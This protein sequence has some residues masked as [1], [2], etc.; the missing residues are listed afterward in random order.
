MLLSRATRTHGKEGLVARER[1][2]RFTTWTRREF[3]RVTTAFGLSVPAVSR[4]RHVNADALG[5]QGRD[6]DPD[7]A[8][9]LAEW[10]YFWVGVDQAHLARRSAGS[11]RTSGPHW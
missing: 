4:I 3:L 9:D 6:T 8:L 7:R 1:P 11:P 2:D 5:R 10:S